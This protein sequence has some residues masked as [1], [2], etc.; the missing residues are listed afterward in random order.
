MNRISAERAQKWKDAYE[1]GESALTIAL[2]DDTTEVT[3]RKYLRL[4][5]TEMR[6]PGHRAGAAMN[7]SNRANARAAKTEP[8][9]HVL[10]Q[11]AHRRRGRTV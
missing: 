4:L 8:K 9:V 3:V 1:A 11:R 7:H 6:P 10:R 2:N 5:G